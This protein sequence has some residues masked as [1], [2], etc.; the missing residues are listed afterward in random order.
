[1]AIKRGSRSRIA[2]IGMSAGSDERGLAGR[3]TVAEPSQGRSRPAMPARWAAVGQ[4]RSSGNPGVAAPAHA[5]GTGSSHLCTGVVGWCKL[6]DPWSLDR[7]PGRLRL[8]A[9]PSSRGRH[10]AWRRRFGPATSWSSTISAR[11][12]RGG[13]RW[14]PKVRGS[15][16]CRPTART[17][18]RSSTPSPSSK[19]C[20]D[21]PRPEPRSA[22]AE[23]RPA[24]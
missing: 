10:R 1:V 17:A 6:S 22:L 11:K 12:V 23:H 18:N 14:R 7:A 15:W 2:T 16:I 5:G 3:P 24:P 19:P 9:A 20:S 13:P 4:R 21:V 8:D